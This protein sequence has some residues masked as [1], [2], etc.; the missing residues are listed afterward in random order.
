MRVRDPL[1]ELAYD[2]NALDK[3]KRAAAAHPRQQ[4]MAVARQV[5]SLFMQLM[6]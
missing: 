3:L 4:A 1:N 6:L 2:S 5:E